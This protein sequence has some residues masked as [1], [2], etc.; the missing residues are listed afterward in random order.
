MGGSSDGL[1]GEVELRENSFV[2]LVVEVPS[3]K[4]LNGEVSGPLD[5]R[6]D[7]LDSNEENRKRQ[8]NDIYTAK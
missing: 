4:N 2:Y 8:H 6:E 7:Q 1:G 3:S 5:H